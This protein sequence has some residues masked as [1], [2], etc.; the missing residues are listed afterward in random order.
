MKLPLPERN[1]KRIVI[2][3]DIARA[4]SPSKSPV[5][6]RCF[7][8]LV[9]LREC[10]HK[11]VFSD[12]LWQ[13]WLGNRSGHAWRWM[14]TMRARKLVDRIPDPRD[15][16]L[17][18]KIGR[19]AETTA[20]LEVMNKDVHLL[21]AALAT[22][23]IVTSKD[24]QAQECFEEMCHGIGEIREVVWANPVSENDACKGW[25]KRGAPPDPQRQLGHRYRER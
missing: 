17:R 14:R 25:L 6:G 12:E 15:P 5:P 24:D 3:A 1:R 8:F 9:T 18:E 2:D 4:A 11:V 16:F 10:K 21:E 20:D 22:D 13:E 19:F 23:R 7:D